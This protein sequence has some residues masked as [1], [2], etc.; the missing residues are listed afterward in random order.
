M[1]LIA[2]ILILVFVR[3]T[4]QIKIVYMLAMQIFTGDAATAMAINLA[5]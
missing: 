5:L 2:E 4:Q 3:A 1:R